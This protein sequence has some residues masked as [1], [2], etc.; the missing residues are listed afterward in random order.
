MT[1]NLDKIFSYIVAYTLNYF[2]ISTTEEELDKLCNE[3][4]NS[5]EFRNRLIEMIEQ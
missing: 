2:N 3:M 5:S 1:I 4:I